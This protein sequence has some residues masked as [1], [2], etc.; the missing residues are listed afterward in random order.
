MSR[1]MTRDGTSK[2]HGDGRRLP[3]ST[4]EILEEQLQKRRISPPDARLPSDAGR[5]SPSSDRKRP[6]SK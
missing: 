1:A 2:L 4:R 3:Q 5:V 6:L